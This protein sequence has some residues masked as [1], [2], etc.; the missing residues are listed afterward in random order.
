[1]LASAPGAGAETLYENVLELIKNHKQ[2]KAKE[3]ELTA[4]HKAIANFIEN[5]RTK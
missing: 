3:A 5:P 2:I 4:T 1:M